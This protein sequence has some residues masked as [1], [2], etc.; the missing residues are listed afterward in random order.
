MWPRRFSASQFVNDCVGLVFHKRCLLL[1]VAV[2]PRQAPRQDEP[3]DGWRKHNPNTQAE[4]EGGHVALFHA[5]GEEGRGASSSSLTWS[6]V[7]GA[8]VTNAT[9]ARDC[10]T[11]SY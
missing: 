2:L 7:A 3:F 10:T 11:T 6:W 5:I 9:G 8:L 1:L 4:I